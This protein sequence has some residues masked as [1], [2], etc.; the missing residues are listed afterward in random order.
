MPPKPEFLQVSWRIK[1][2]QKLN[3]KR[4]SFIKE[5]IVDSCKKKESIFKWKTNYTFGGP[6]NGD[7]SVSQQNPTIVEICPIHKNNRQ[8]FFMFSFHVINWNHYFFNKKTSTYGLNDF[9]DLAKRDIKIMEFF[10]ISTSFSSF[11]IYL[12]RISFQVYIS[13]F[14]KQLCPYIYTEI[15]I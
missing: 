10:K 3:W 9:V 6:L 14:V 12:R 1:G 15:F 11:Y 5:N 4:L 8:N 13:C 7:V 2:V